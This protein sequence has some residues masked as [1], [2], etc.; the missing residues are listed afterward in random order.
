[1][2]FVVNILTPSKVLAKNIQ[3]D[4]L[5]V[6]TI[7]GTINILKDHTHLITKIDT[8]I[9]T[10]INGQ[11][12]KHFIITT[13]ICRILGNSV[14]VL[15][16]VGEG[17]TQIDQERAEVALKRAK[18]RLKATDN[19]TDEEILKFQRKLQRAELR[20]QASKLASH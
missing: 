5:L 9:M 18:E 20:L 12:K 2:S 17:T 13:G 1:M 3:A 19:L 11:D 10:C 6:P 16:N 7:K 4:S 8:G 14:T 15:T